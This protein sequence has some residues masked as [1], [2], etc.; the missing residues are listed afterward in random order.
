MTRDVADFE[1]DRSRCVRAA[2]PE[3]ALL[4]HYER[5][6]RRDLVQRLEELSESM[7]VVRIQPEGWSAP[8]PQKAVAEEGEP[9]A[10]EEAKNEEE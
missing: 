5:H 7:E 4:E 8:L 3:E 6:V 9:Y 1:V 10:V 2:W